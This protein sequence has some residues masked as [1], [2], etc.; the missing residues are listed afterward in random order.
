[1]KKQDKISCYEIEKK[2]TRQLEE[3]VKIKDTNSHQFLSLMDEIDTIFNLLYNESQ[4]QNY[5]WIFCSFDTYQS[6]KEL[7]KQEYQNKYSE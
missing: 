1:M 7:R 4:Q 2:L 6:G 3:I 5:Y